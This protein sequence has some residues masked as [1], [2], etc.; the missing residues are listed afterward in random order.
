MAERVGDVERSSESSRA[1]PIV[2]AAIPKNSNKQTGQTPRKKRFQSAANEPAA[3]SGNAKPVPVA[4]A[5]PANESSS[6]PVLSPATQKRPLPVAPL[7]PSGNVA[8]AAGAATTK[9]P[10]VVGLPGTRPTE[11]TANISTRQLQPKNVLEPDADE[12]ESVLAAAFASVYTLPSWLISFIV[13]MVLLLLLALLS[14]GSPQ[15]RAMVLELTEAQSVENLKMFELAIEPDEVKLDSEMSELQTEDLQDLSADLEADLEDQLSGS[16]ESGDDDVMGNDLYQSLTKS[17]TGSQGGA[18]EG[19]KFYGTGASGN[20]FV[21]VIDCSGSM[22]NQYR[23]MSAKREL[24]EAIERLTTKQRFFVFLYNHES[25][26]MQRKTARMLPATNRNKK[27]AFR[28]LDRQHP[29]G[30]TKPWNSLKA[31]LKIEP[32]A[33]FLLSDGELNDDTERNLKQHNKVRTWS[34][35]DRG[36][37]PIHTISL[38]NGFGSKTMERISKT[39]GGTFTRVVK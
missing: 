20:N 2:S 5:L 24:K 8:S 9:A 28:W 23:W 26:P 11:P 1:T 15:V 32:D 30:D 29:M 34:N 14:M 27:D 25:Y 6:V 12:Q 36:K 35:G 21:F 37:T 33:I 38:G 3:K 13:H 17:G 18:G 19:A 4:M 39:N 10:I 7:M 22:A 16:V 31:S